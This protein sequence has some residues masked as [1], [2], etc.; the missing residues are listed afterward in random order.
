MKN[1][2]L[3]LFSALCLCAKAQVSQQLIRINNVAN[4]A[5]L[6][7]ISGPSA[8]QLAYVID[9]TRTYQYD[10]TIWKLLA[11]NSAISE[12]ID[13]DSDTW[14]KVDDGNDND[15]IQFSNQGVINHEIDGTLFKFLNTQESVFIGNPGV[16]STKSVI[17]SYEGSLGLASSSVDFDENVAVGGNTLRNASVSAQ[18][19]T[20]VGNFMYTK[21]SKG[22]DFNTSLGA[23]NF[24]YPLDGSE[25]V[26][27]SDMNTSMGYK[28]VRKA[29]GASGNVAF[30][31]NCLIN[32]NYGDKNVAAPFNTLNDN[33]GGGSNIALGH[34]ALNSIN[35]SNN[36]GIG[37]GASVPSLSLDNQ[38]KIGANGPSITNYAGIQVAWNTSSDLH[39]KDSVQSLA[40]GLNLIKELRPVNY[41]RK[42]SFQKKREVG[43]IAQELEVA[44]AKVGYHDQGFLTK[45]DEG[46]FEV[47]Y[48]DF[49]GIAINAIK[50]QEQTITY[51]Q[52]KI[53]NYKK[54]MAQMNKTLLLLESQ[55]GTV[56]K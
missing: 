3:I 25:T 34:E 13:G 46:L 42:G 43:F 18:S 28:L 45:T 10:G 56:K 14:I 26:A 12:I 35:Q 2:L 7:N 5:T 39:W 52:E 51:Q 47:R 37:F 33:T 41:L 19:N 30:G 32:T 40:Y 54:E 15:I 38:C 9:Q 29:M 31:F 53:G 48:N 4:L 1:I 44:L 23:E 11:P 8:G 17:I 49:I 22:G 27:H 21:F 16:T 20:H 50:E 36:I 6:N 55:I 24:G